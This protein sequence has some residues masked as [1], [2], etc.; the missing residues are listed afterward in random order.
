MS[1]TKWQWS[2]VEVEELIEAYNCKPPDITK[3]AFSV[4]WSGKVNK[5]PDGVRS[6]VDKQMV[7]GR[8]NRGHIPES[9]YPVYDSPLTMEGN[10]VILP[11]LEA[12]FHHADFVNR[13]LDL[14]GVWGIRQAILPGDAV[15]LDA[16]SGWQPNWKKENGGGVTEGAESK[17][18]EFAKTLSKHKQGELFV[19]L[20]D[21]GKLDV[22]DGASTE[23]NEAGKVLRRLAD[24]F[25]AIDY[26][27]G[28]HEG[29]TLRTM[30]TA[31]NPQIL[32]D[33][34]AIPDGQRA[35]W[36]TAPYYFS[37]LV[38]N[39]ERFQIEHPKNAVKFS[40]SKLCAKFQTH[41][42]MSHGHQLSFAFDVSG[43]FYAIE[44]GH[45]CDEMRLPYCSQR[46][47]ISPAHALG[48]VIVRDGYPHLL[49][50]RTEWGQIKN[51]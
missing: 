38:S 20:G 16:F 48:A 5:T 24:Q 46:H 32:L 21:I 39:G 22:E 10:A 37:I 18:V 2:D 8:I 34:V 1:N 6:Q 47:N 50:A 44:M 33:L 35:K 27:M 14:A 36:R 7:L 41:V 31:L 43:K 23:L 40:V 12:P 28:N 30:A 19:L 49:H 51:M 25:D 4:L 13:V 26:N 45:C 9:P 15:H 17:L 3:R 42:L 11:D 29:R